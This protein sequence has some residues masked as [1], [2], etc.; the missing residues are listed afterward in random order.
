MKSV[1]PKRLYTKNQKFALLHPKLPLSN[2]APQNPKKSIF[3][4]KS[5]KRNF[6]KKSNFFLIPSIFDR[7]RRGIS[8]PFDEE[9]KMPP[10]PKVESSPKMSHF[11]GEKWKSLWKKVTKKFQNF[12]ILSFLN[13]ARRGISVP[14]WDYEKRFEI[15]KF[16][17]KWYIFKKYTPPPKEKHDHMENR[18][19][20]YIWNGP[21]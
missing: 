21:K 2:R 5:V 18:K 7:S 4:E 20:I 13:A 14:F 15:K 11:W 8:A 12:P 17:K 10:W 3:P 6:L 16:L 1:A 9:K 19:K